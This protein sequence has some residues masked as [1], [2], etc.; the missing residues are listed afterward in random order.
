MDM[1]INSASIDYQA[2]LIAVD[3]DP[4]AAEPQLLTTPATASQTEIWLSVQMGDA[5][6]LFQPAYSLDRIE[7]MQ[8]NAQ[9]EILSDQQRLVS[10]L[11]H[12]Q[13]L[14]CLDTDWSEIAV[15]STNSPRV[16]ISSDDLAYVIYTSGSTSQ[17][18]GLEVLDRGV[19]NTYF[20]Y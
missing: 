12:L 7:Y 8:R 19:V 11:P 10:A 16:E 17:P 18:K 4:F 20:N 1:N 5:D 2:N 3:F 13:Q 6:N 15:S 9:V 14:I